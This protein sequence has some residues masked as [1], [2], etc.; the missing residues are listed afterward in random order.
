[1]SDANQ[2]EGGA[3][4]PKSTVY[5][6]LT[7]DP[8]MFIERRF[9]H[10]LLADDNDQQVARL[11]WP[12]VATLLIDPNLIAQF[13]PFEAEAK[14]L[15]SLVQWLGTIA[16]LLMFAALF[17]SAYE[18]WNSSGSPQAVFTLDWTG[19][20]VE[21]CGILG[22]ILALLA[23]KYGP[24]RRSWLQNRF[25]TEVL[26]QWHFRYLLDTRAW[27]PQPHWDSARFEQHRADD[28]HFLQ[29]GLRGAVGQRMDLLVNARIDP[30]GEIPKA[31][32]PK[33]AT[34]QRE[35]IDAY[36]RLRLDHQIEFAEYKLSPDDRTFMRLSLEALVS[37]T[38]Q[39]AGAALV[40]A[41]GCS[42][43]R[44]FQPLPWVSFAAVALAVVGVAIRAWR[45]GLS[46]REERERYDEIRHRL[47]LLRERWH[48]AANDGARFTIAV[49]VEQAAAE[50]LRSFIHCHMTAQF[51]F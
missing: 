5:D 22:L 16:V 6:P 29:N 31:H 40:L 4:P 36:R 14:R 46:L 39:L 7:H 41:L 25:V 42:I 34:A 23:S 51:L 21:V 35:I 1:M 17:V 9:N 27:Q 43:A 20:F 33:D 48:S 49:E 2:R 30:V 28:L 44:L 15:K 32:L 45:D 47:G 3:A 38:N 13:K 50:E 8:A 12:T 18:L 11:R 26:R 37:I 10:D 24:F 19:I